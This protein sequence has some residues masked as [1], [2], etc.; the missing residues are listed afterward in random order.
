MKLTVFGASGGTGSRVVEQALAA[1]HAVTAVV[2]DPSRLHLEDD[3]V[4]ADG[5]VLEVV[6]ADVRDPAAVTRA[7]RG[8]DAVISTLG[9]REKGPTT[10][11]RDSASSITRAMRES[12]VSRLLVVSNSGNY[13]AGD[14][15]PVHLLVKP[16]LRRM[17]RHAYADMDAME[18]LVRDSELDWTIVRPPQ[19]TDKP[20]TGT[21]H[22]RLD[23]NVRGGFRISRADLAHYLLGA[24]T[25]DSVTRG[26]VSVA[27]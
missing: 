17:L 20:Y 25:E 24:V 6:T 12:G 11:C 23:G 8:R 19:L 5:G 14:A 27:G 18:R 22:S 1:G 3:H 13:T 9:P 21:V 10:V 15:L 4:R 7:V 26:T 16:L 2:R